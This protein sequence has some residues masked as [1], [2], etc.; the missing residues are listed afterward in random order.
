[1]SSEYDTPTTLE[2]WAGSQNLN[3]TLVFTD[4]VDSTAIGRRLGDRAWIE[5]LFRHFSQARSLASH[6]DCYVVKV[7]GDSLMMAF[8]TST[9]AVDFAVT[10]LVD[11][12]VA[13][14]GIRVGINSGQVHIREND[15][16]GLNVNFTSRVQ[17][18]LPREGILISNSVKRDC[19]KT[20]G[21]DSPVRFNPREENLKSFGAE[22]VY[23]TFLP[24]FRTAIRR[25][26]PARA[27][28]LGITQSSAQG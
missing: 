9:D 1:M 12:G 21:I 15:I 18:A 17:H 8:R 13:H 7:I 25:Q 24:G 11:T 26:R 14:I 6:Y 19:E 16:Y 22:T 23:F 10:F 4:I 28:L 2:E 27:L 5:D 3:L 20:F